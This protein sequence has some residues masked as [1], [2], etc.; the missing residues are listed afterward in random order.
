MEGLSTG[1]DLVCHALHEMLRV[2]RIKED[3]LQ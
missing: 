3:R 2:P 1:R